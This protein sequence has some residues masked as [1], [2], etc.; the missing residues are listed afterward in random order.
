MVSK[1]LASAEWNN[2]TLLKGNIVEE[3]S[4]LKQGDGQN[5][6]ILGS[7]DLVGQLAQHGLIDEYLLIVCP[8]L[9]GNGKRLFQD[10]INTT[11]KLVA[12]RAYSTGVLSLTYQPIEG[13]MV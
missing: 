8:L 7:A 3:V 9:L 2:T 12:S 5:I 6:L 4:Q 10:G 1:T 13:R 11:L